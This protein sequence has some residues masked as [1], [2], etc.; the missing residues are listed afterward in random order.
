MGREV[1]VT[2]FGVHT[3]HGRG[4]PAVR[5]GV[6]AGKAAFAPVTR[7]DTSPYR[8]SVAATVPGDP[9]LLEVLAGCVED[10]LTMAGRADGGDMPF[11]LGCLGDFGAITRFWRDGPSADTVN[12]TPAVVADTIAD[13]FSL[14]GKRLTYT[15]ACVA[16]AAAIIHGWQLVSS[17]RADTVVCAGVYLLE[18]ATFGQFDS[19]LAISL[20]STLRPFSA[21]RRGMLLGDGAAVVVIESAD[22]ARRRGSTPLARIT[23]WG[24]ASDA[25]HIAKPHPD[26]K[27][28]ALA[29]E[30]ALR[31]SG[32]G[33]EGIGY[34]NAHG[35]GT[36][37][38]DSA[39]TNGLRAVFGASADAIPVSSTKSTTGHLM[40]ASGA[41]EFVISLLALM[42]NVLP[43]TAGYT[44]P[45]PACDL[46]YVTEGPRAAD[47][48]RVLTLN[49]AFGGMNTAILLES[50]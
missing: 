42:D 31:M 7:F 39:E 33:P 15:N 25:Y 35:T 9:E 36:R 10:A 13:R 1:V 5:D 26:G 46:D 45:D 49:A 41:V 17:G 40:A 18:E 23:G 8:G 44:T 19:G 2:G 48:R 47:L 29:V 27:G 28:L 16:S 3:A 12:G 20:D 50:P 11:L 6:F 38:N 24:L 37:L 14:R 34:V 4:A 22:V 21:D 30:Q 43:P 32:T